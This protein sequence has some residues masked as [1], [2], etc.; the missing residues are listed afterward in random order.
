MQIINQDTMKN[1]LLILTSFLFITNSNGQNYN[2]VNHEYENF[3]D[4]PQDISF[5]EDADGSI[6]VLGNGGFTGDVISV[7]R[8]E[9]WES[10]PFDE[11]GNCSYRLT[12]DNDG[13]I[14][15][16]TN[17]GFFAYEGGSWVSKS[18]DV[19]SNGE[20]GF[21]SQGNLWFTSNDDPK[22]LAFLDPSGTVSKIDEVQD[23][24]RF[25]VV[26]G[27]DKV[28]FYNEQ[29]IKSYS[30]D[31]LESFDGSANHLA[32][33]SENTLW[34][35][36]FQGVIGKI[37]GSDV[38]TN[39]FSNASNN[40]Q[41][42]SFAIDRN[43]DLMYIGQQGFDAGVMM[44]NLT[45]G[46]NQFINSDGLFPDEVGLVNNL[47]VSSNGTVWAGSRFSPKIAEIEVDIVSNVIDQELLFNVFPNPTSN[48]ISLNN[49]SKTKLVLSVLSL[50]GITIDE[51]E[52]P[53]GSYNLDVS[54][55]TQ[56]S[57]L[58]GNAE[59]GFKKIQIVR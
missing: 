8:N 12:S 9:V 38:L 46:T 56:G 36:D 48:L 16:A 59:I 31:G 41:A 54:S 1:F 33:D 43:N 28:W 17:I 34:F 7:Y 42:I 5:A 3:H 39:Q 58:I 14:Y 19:V 18:G 30:S 52:L 4:F 6:W 20:V 21:D 22:K 23:D 40:F 24:I 37:V 15:L 32:V 27:D 51:I 49:N 50:A 13:V 35:V 10:V 2:I 26:S 55:Y 11:C 47:F 44:A 45:D 57:Y 29:L 53:L 25:M